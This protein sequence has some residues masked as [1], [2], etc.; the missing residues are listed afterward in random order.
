MEES[1]L[2]CIISLVWILICGKNEAFKWVFWFLPGCLFQEEFILAFKL[3]Q[4]DIQSYFWSKGSKLDT[5]LTCRT[6]FFCKYWLTLPSSDLSDV[7]F[8]D[9]AQSEKSKENIRAKCVQYLDRAEKLKKHV[10]GEKS[11]PK[12]PV[13][14]GSGGS[15]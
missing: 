15:K 5:I 3:L 11:E 9:E 13:K 7:S 10:A 12:K 14:S 8:E 2:Q 6:F 1:C 4:C